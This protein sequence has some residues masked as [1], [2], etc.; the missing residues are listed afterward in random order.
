MGIYM[1]ELMDNVTVI[2]GTTINGRISL[3]Q[4]SRE[5]LLGVPGMTEEIVEQIL[6]QRTTQPEIEDPTQQ[7]E[8]WLLTTGI[9]T[10]EEMKTMMPFV[11]AGG[12]TYRAQV[13]GYY[14]DG[15]ASAR[16]E[17]IIDATQ[18][19]PRLLLWR[20]ISYLGRGYALETLGASLG[21]TQE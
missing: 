14:E 15:R 11:C 20:D 9:V 1:T 19:P 4:A 16:V 6:G 8:T 2:Q 3:N 17:V 21:I 18:L 5:I 12:D 13:V 7:H 10:L